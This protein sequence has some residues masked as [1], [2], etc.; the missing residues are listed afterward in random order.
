MKRPNTHFKIPTESLRN[1]IQD[2]K[3]DQN[4]TFSIQNRLYVHLVMYDY[5]FFFN[6]PTRTS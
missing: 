3:N 1:H 2:R 5:G 6:F 4:D